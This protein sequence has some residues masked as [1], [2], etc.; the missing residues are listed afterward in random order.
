MSSE[1]GACSARHSPG[2]PSTRPLA[3]LALLGAAVAACGDTSPM[4]GVWEEEAEEVG[5]ML[6]YYEDGSGVVVSNACEVSDRFR[7]TYL[8]SGILEI[9]V[10]DPDPAGLYTPPPGQIARIVVEWLDSRRTRMR[11]R[12]PE[13][14]DELAAELTLLDRDPSR[15]ERHCD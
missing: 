8:E 11:F 6:V 9:V 5:E 2:S 1:N 10:T 14:G 7:W 3:L 12:D 13:S 4:V 15:Y